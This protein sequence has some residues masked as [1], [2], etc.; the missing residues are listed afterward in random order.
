MRISAFG[1]AK[2]ILISLV[3]TVVRASG[4]LDF[5]TYQVDNGIGYIPSPD[6]KGMFLHLNDWAFND[7]SMGPTRRGI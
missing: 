3:S 1:V 6:Q 4:V 2:L 7:R 5:P